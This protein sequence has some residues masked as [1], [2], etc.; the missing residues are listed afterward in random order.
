MTG[1]L[2]D[3]RRFA[4]DVGDRDGLA[5]RRVDLWAAGQWLTC[6]DNMAYV[7]QFRH[8]VARTATWVRS[9]P[10]P[11]RPFDMSPAAVHRRLLAEI[12]DGEQEY[13]RFGFF[14]RWGWGPTTDNVTSFLWREEDGLVIT[15]EFWREAH[16]LKHP[17][18]AGTV[19]VA[20]LQAVELTGI[21]EETATALGH[22]Q[23]LPVAGE[24]SAGPDAD[25]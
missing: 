12:M 13:E 19:F 5:L 3:K 4:V 14:G 16:L 23:G 7:D 2:G 20:E 18:Q 22:G 6:D 11:V 9:G 15:L 21:L 8:A 10:V 25:A 1:L 17:E 24:L